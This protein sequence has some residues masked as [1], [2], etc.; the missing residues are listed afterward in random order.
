MTLDQNAAERAA[1]EG[2][3]REQLHQ[4]ASAMGV[5]GATRLRKA[6]L[7]D[8]IV[9]AATGG[10]ATNGDA[11]TPKPRATRARKTAEPAAAAT[12]DA[13]PASATNGATDTAAAPAALPAADAT[14]PLDVPMAAAPATAVTEA[15]PDAAAPEAAAASTAPATTAPAQQPSQQPSQQ[16]D[17]G[18][19]ERQPQF[20]NESKRSRRRRRGRDRDRMPGEHTQGEP[21]EPRQNEP[22]GEPIEVEGLLEIRDEGYGFLRTG[23]YLA[24]KNDVYVSASQVRR[25]N[26]R[27]GDYVK[28]AT[29]PAANNE[30]YPALL[31]VDEINDMT[32]DDARMRPRFED[33]TPLFPDQKLKLETSPTNMT[34]R[35]IDLISPIGKGQRG[36]IVSPP[37]AGKTT[38]MKQIVE[39]IESN[40]PEVHLMVLLVEERPEEVTDMRRHVQRGE[41]VASTFDRPSDE[42]TQ[43]AELTIERAKRLAEM[44]R[45]VV[46]IL[47]GIT[48]L[49]RAYNLSAPASGRILSGG[50]DSGALYPPRKFFGAARNIE[51][52]GSL[53]ILA[54]ALVE[55]GSR[56]DE[57]IFEEFKGTGNM[58]LRLDRKLSER[59]IYPSIDVEASSTRHEELLFDRVQLQ[60]VWKLRRVLN[61]LEGGAGLELLMDKIKTTRSNDEFLAEIAKAPT[62]G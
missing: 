31:R 62:P 58:E 28:G 51:E 60:Q 13:A 8:A 56:M 25:F 34:G 29:R 5:K 18:G 15:A 19:W 1:L 23:G 26:L 47:D 11:A 35:I 10:A 61:A 42:H 37:K 9:E 38:I 4:I 20:G 24:G 45:D 53:T 14:S 22:V 54:T 7:V 27:K 43:V 40:N 12:T 36:L 46:I 3:D 48:R 33:L 2:K 32:P 55:T 59:R 21:R 52:G 41:V 16:P 6:E 39:S 17:H 57:V 30:K 50:V 44:G 49:A